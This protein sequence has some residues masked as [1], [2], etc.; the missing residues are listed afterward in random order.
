MIKQMTPLTLVEAKKIAD[1]HNVE[2]ES[3]KPYFK[4]FIKLKAKDIEEMR[5][6][7]EGFNNH[8]I[9]P[10]H[11]IKIIDFLPEDA[12]EVN[13]IF[14]DISLDENEIKQITDV[15]KKYK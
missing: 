5:K 15:T 13:K 8:K 12:S 11:I 6:E 7:L 4:K 9:K 14:T 1:E 3:L 2:S 10:E